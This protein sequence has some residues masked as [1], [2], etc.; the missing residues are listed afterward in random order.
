MAVSTWVAMR[1]AYR[2]QLWLFRSDPAQLLVFVVAPVLSLVF[3]AIMKNADRSDLIPNAV[4]APGLIA[5]WYISLDIAGSIV[6]DDRWQ[7]TL[8]L[9]VAA[10]AA[11]LAPVLARVAAVV[12]IGMLSLVE[13][14]LVAVLVFGIPVP[15]AHPVALILTLLA[16]A[17]AMIGTSVIVAAVF[18]LARTALVLANALTYPVYV[19]SGILVPVSMLPDF[20]QPLS[21]LIF[22]SWAAELLRDSLAGPPVQHL[23]ARLGVIL[24]LGAAG[25][26]AGHLLMRS[27]LNRVRQTGTVGRR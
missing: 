12:S 5:L 20:L 26:A 24:L 23:A 18:V 17:L 21:R 11:V 6:D 22:L 1:G 15:I 3:L 9:L 2:F 7:G 16:T 25:Y 19:L 14:P 4:V 13:A 10:P 8:E 27:T